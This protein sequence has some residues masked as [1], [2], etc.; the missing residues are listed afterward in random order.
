MDSLL[1]R[2]N[3]LPTAPTNPPLQLT[4]VPALEPDSETAVPKH[5]STAKLQPSATATEPAARS[6]TRARAKAGAPAAATTARST[7]ARPTRRPASSR[8]RAS[9]RGA[10]VGCPETQAGSRAGAAEPGRVAG[11]RGEAEPAA[12][13]EPLGREGVVV[14]GRNFRRTVVV[15]RLRCGAREAWRAPWRRS[16]S[17]PARP[18]PHRRRF[19][20]RCRLRCRLRALRL[21]RYSSR[22]RGGRRRQYS[23]WPNTSQS[24][25]SPLHFQLR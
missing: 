3:L 8:A 24:H 13:A 11:S 7:A 19:R 23:L 5:P 16:L 2:L 12:R 18:S 10:A 14:E 20:L 21:D 22:P 4:V 1:E 15:S 25:M 6:S 17:T 9:R